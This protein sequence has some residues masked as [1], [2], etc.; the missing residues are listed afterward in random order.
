MSAAPFFL[1]QLASF[2]GGVRAGMVV[3]RASAGFVKVVNGHACPWFA[4][5]D[6][7]VGVE[8]FALCI[9]SIGYLGEGS[10]SILFEFGCSIGF[11]NVSPGQSGQLGP[12]SCLDP[13]C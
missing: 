8:V 10:G 12:H 7:D 2:P 3:S 9:G 5:V 13:Q 11:E 4:A 1:A 6:C